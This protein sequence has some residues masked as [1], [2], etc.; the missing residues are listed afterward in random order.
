[1]RGCIYKLVLTLK[2]N[3]KETV[4]IALSEIGRSE[5]EEW[6]FIASAKGRY[7]WGHHPYTQTKYHVEGRE[8]YAAALGSKAKDSR[9][10]MFIC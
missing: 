7:G 9:L 8:S 10:E 6:E 2:E 5:E 3:R 4:K 1:M